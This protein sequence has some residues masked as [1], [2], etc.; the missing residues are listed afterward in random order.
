MYYLYK[1][2]TDTWAWQHK[3]ADITMMLMYYIGTILPS[4]ISNA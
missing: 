3:S 2:S 4:Y 1:G